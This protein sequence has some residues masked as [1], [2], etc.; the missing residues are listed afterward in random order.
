MITMDSAR[1]R[2]FSL[3]G[4]GAL[5]VFGIVLF[6]WLQ[7]STDAP[8][9]NIVIVL[10]DTVRADHTSLYGY[11]RATTP[12]LER[13]AAKGLVMRHHF[14]NAPWTKPSVASM[15][16]GVHPGMHGARLSKPTADLFDENIITL[17]ERLQ[18]SGYG[19]HAFINNLHLNPRHGFAQGYDIYQFDP[20][21]GLRP[22]VLTS[23]WTAIDKAIETLRTTLT[24]EHQSNPVFVWSH[25]MSVHG[26]QAPQAQ[27]VFSA[28]SNKTPVDHSTPQGWRMKNFSFVED[29]IAKYDNSILFADFLIGRLMD[30]IATEC[31]NTILV[32]TSDHGEEFYEHGDFE[33]MHT[34]YNELLCVPLVISGPGVPVGEVTGLSDSLDIMPTLLELAGIKSEWDASDATSGRPLIQ[35]GKISAGKQEVFSEQDERTLWR[36][37][38]LL[39]KDGKLIQREAREDAKITEEFYVPGTEIEKEDLISQIDASRLDEYRERI[40]QL[41]RTN[42]EHLE[43]TI[44]TEAEKVTLDEDDLKNLKDMGYL[45]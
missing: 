24:S 26:Y 37:R 5:L 35:N 39:R 23:D 29:A 44:G 27:S 2:R 11:S 28:E 41:R 45:N 16:S 18:S 7:L 8:K 10:I 17:A 13:L 14:T 32:V 4:L 36:R 31:P 30:F 21:G 42:Q 6:T 38:S 22:N 20:H 33:H 19:T 3:I 25:L 43:A 1:R 12:N 34:L 15:L 40:A 9:P